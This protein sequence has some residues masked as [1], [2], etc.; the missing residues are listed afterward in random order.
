MIELGLMFLF[1][2][3]LGRNG[4]HLMPYTFFNF[5]NEVERHGTEQALRSFAIE[6]HTVEEIQKF[7]KSEKLADAV[8]FVSKGRITLL[9]SEQNVKDAER[10]FSAA[11]NAGVDLSG[12]QWFDK[13]DMFKVCIGTHLR[14]PN[15]SSDIRFSAT[16]PITQE[17]NLPLTISGQSSWSRTYTPSPKQ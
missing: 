15:P 10:D 1:L 11:K 9:F 4:G 6:H 12:V 2:L 13:A 5:C 8:D 7:L 3:H 17:S 14:H 16:G